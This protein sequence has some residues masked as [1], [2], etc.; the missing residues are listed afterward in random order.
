MIRYFGNINF[1][2]EVLEKIQNKTSKDKMLQYVGLICNFEQELKTML[3]KLKDN[4][5]LFIQFG[6]IPIIMLVVVIN[7]FYHVNQGLSPWKGGA[8]GM[9]STYYP[10]QS[11]I[12]INGINYVDSIR[13]DNMRN[14][15]LRNYLFYPK[16]PNL[17]ALIKSIAHP[18]DTLHI[19]IWQPQLNAKNS[20]YSRKLIHEQIYIQSRKRK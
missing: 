7:H 10:E 16:K 4:A 5:H 20:F 8:F 14:R 11:Q 9:Y 2:L 18:N 19:E 17:D 13:K 3:R 15:S 12:Y 6:L 1:K